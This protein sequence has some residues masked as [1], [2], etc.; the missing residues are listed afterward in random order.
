MSA[1]LAIAKAI[2]A[3][4]TFL[5]RL[6][7]YLAE[8]RAFQA[9]EDRATA[10]SLKDQNDRARKARA[11]RNAVDADGVPDDDPYLRD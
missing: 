5:S 4:G 6:A 8:R 11:A 3:V 10:R 2:Y 9:G 1:L 7:D